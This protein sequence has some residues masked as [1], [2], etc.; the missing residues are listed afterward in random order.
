MARIRLLPLSEAPLSVKLAFF[1]TKKGFEKLTGRL[2]ERALEPLGVFAHTPDILKAYGRLE[3][4]TAKASRV[5]LRL[6]DLANLKAATVVQCEYCIDL[7]SKVSRRSG[8]D[9]AQL[10]A[11]PNHRESDLFSEL[12]KLVLDYATVLSR[13]P[14]DVPDE[15]FDQ[16]RT[17]LDD[18]Q[19]VELTHVV[20]I[21][22]YRGRMN[23]AFGIGAAGFSEGMVCAIPTSA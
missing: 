10:L 5:P 6:K 13:T 9:D 23:G 1:F 2:P 7:G 21:E 20:A 16:L 14:I 8:I 22:A 11:L 19:L 12:D 17:H 15:L 3:Q 4:A 18:A